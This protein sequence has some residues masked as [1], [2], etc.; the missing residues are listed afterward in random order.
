MPD[1]DSVAKELAGV[2]STGSES[3][4]RTKLGWLD[5][6][7]SETRASIID[8][9][10]PGDDT[11]LRGFQRYVAHVKTELQAGRDITDSDADGDY[12]EGCR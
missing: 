2:K 9:N 3:W 5:R 6:A 10:A 1:Y 8:A 7:L 4:V 11:E 12:P